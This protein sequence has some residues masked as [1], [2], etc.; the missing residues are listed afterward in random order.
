MDKDKGYTIEVKIH[1][2]SSRRGIEIKNSVHHLFTPKNPISGEANEDAIKIIAEKYRIA[3]KNIT[4]I[5]G[6]KS[7]NKVFRIYSG[8]K[9][10]DKE[11]KR[12]NG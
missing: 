7:R 12:I 1:T 11:R 6:N 10:R 5:K 2:G 8:N 9:N 3:K 4:I